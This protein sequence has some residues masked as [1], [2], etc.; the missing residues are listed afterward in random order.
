MSIFS[1]IFGT[2]RTE[3]EKKVIGHIEN[4]VKMLRP[5]YNELKGFHFESA[6]IS[7]YY[8]LQFIHHNSPEKYNQIENVTYSYL[9]ELGNKVSNKFNIPVSLFINNRFEICKNELDF[10]L[11]NQRWDIL[12]SKSLYNLYINPLNVNSGSTMDI[13]LDFSFKMKFKSYIQ[14]CEQGLPILIQII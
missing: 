6:I 9:R 1:S 13:T 11:R 7:A 8:M 2:S 5:E 10:I 14:F 12:P 3:S 4:G